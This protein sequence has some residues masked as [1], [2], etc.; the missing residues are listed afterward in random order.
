VLLLA[1]T[2]WTADPIGL[3]VAVQGA[4]T[5]AAPQGAPRSL[6]MKSD[7]FLHDEVVT[8]AGARLQIMLNDD[9]L[10]AQGEQSTMTIDEFMY[11][12]AQAK[13]NA[14]GVQLGK[15]LF[16][17]VTG[18]ITD[19]NPDRFKVRTSRA[20]IGIR[21]CDLGFDITPS[22][23]NISVMAVPPGKQIFIDPIAGDQ[24]LL[25]EGPLF[26]R[27]DDR[28]MLEQREL[29]SSDRQ[30]AQ[31]GTTP[32][33]STEPVIDPDDAGMTDG[34]LLDGAGTDGAGGES[35]IDEGSI[36]QDTEQQHTV[37]EDHHHY[38]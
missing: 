20:N 24:S 31:Q 7:I 14:F 4:A 9:S 35:I 27:I 22:E 1:A 18:K 28:G 29:T 5:A 6:Q 38:H 11:N 12:P 3:V 32:G 13:D 34:G 23:D 37:E 36:I 17:T 25:V 8:A 26:V 19:M 16:R 2:G 21:G 10:I 15:G 30:S 33:A